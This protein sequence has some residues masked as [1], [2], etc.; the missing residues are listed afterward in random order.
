MAQIPHTQHTPLLI[1][2]HSLQTFTLLCFMNFKFMVA[3]AFYAHFLNHQTVKYL[4]HLQ[5]A[6]SC[7]DIFN[8]L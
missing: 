7:T 8:C 4:S 6:Y 5:L 3:S 1:Y 2:C